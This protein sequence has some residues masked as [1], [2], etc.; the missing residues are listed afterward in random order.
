[1]RWSS[2]Q[3]APEEYPPCGNTA[4]IA[5]DPA[6]PYEWV[7]LDSVPRMFSKL[8]SLNEFEHGKNYMQ[9]KPDIP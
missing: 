6:K 5:S 7:D 1:M 4:V 2:A 9:Q 8:A 3:V